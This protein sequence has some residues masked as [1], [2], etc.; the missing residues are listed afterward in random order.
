MKVKTLLLFL[1][2]SAVYAQ[3]PTEAKKL[4]NEGIVLHDKGDY[5]GA[6]NNYNKAL[7]ADKDNIGALTEKA[8]SLSAAGKYDEAINSPQ[9]Q[10]ETVGCIVAK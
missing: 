4:I 5:A 7:E 1:F 9:S 10:N 2:F 6:V 3:N 8:M